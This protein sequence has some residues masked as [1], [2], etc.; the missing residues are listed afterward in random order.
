MDCRIESIIIIIIIIIIVIII[1]LIII[2]FF[3]GGGGGI[4]LARAQNFFRK[5]N[6]SYPSYTRTCVFFVKLCAHTK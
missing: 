1:I 3:L 2:I 4:C 6:I 5:T